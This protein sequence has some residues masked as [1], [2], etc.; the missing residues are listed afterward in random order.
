MITYKVIVVKGD[1]FKLE[2]ELNWL[3]SIGASIVS[4]MYISDEV[5]NVVYL[6][7]EYTIADGCDEVE[8]ESR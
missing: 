1:I 7:D 4:V 2:E 5:Y 8:Y 6:R 3:S